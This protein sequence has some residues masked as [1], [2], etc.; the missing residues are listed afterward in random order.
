MSF[1]TTICDYIQSEL[2]AD[3]GIAVLRPEDDLLESGMLD[4]LDV[5]RLV[6]FLETRFD[7]HI[8]QEDVTLNHFQ[9]VQTISTYLQSHR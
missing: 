7:I 9:S 3:K 2:L 6:H 1:E 8:P 5:I 4:S